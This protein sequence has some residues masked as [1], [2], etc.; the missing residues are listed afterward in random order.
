MFILSVKLFKNMCLK[1]IVLFIYH[2]ST[3]LNS[4]SWQKLYSNRKT[5]LGYKE[6]KFILVISLCSFVNNQCLP[7]IE[8]KEKYNSWNDCTLAALE[9]SKQL[10][11]S[12]EDTFINKKKIATK[13]VAKELIN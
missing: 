1:N 10:I 5:G 8:V 9:I 11:I 13:K 7:P 4:W 3:K 2:W 12:Q 6:M